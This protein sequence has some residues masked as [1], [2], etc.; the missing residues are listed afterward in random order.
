[1]KHIFSFFLVFLFSQ[2][3]LAQSGADIT[4]EA[5]SNNR[6]EYLTAGKPGTIYV[7]KRVN[8]AISYLLEYNGSKWNNISPVTEGFDGFYSMSH[9]GKETLYCYASTKTDGTHLYR[10][11]GT[12]WDTLPL[13]SL[14]GR[15]RSVWVSPNGQLF[16]RGKFKNENGSYFIATWKNEQWQ[17]VGQPVDHRFLNNAFEQYAGNNFGMDGAGTLFVEIFRYEKGN[18][19]SYIAKWDGKKWGLLDTSKY[20][21]EGSISNMAVSKN[22]NIYLAGYFKDANGKYCVP[23]WDGKKWN[24]YTT[25]SNIYDVAVDASDKLY[26]AGWVMSKSNYVVQTWE[27]DSWTDYASSDGFFQNIVFGNNSLYAVVNSGNANVYQLV[28]GGLTTKS[29][30][31]E[32]N[33]TSSTVSNSS[34]AVTNSST[35]ATQPAA[36]PHTDKKAKEMWSVYEDFKTAFLPKFKEIDQLLRSMLE[37]GD[38][39]KF[40]NQV[41]WKSSAYRMKQLIPPAYQTIQSIRGKISALSLQKG[42]NYLAD[43]LQEALNAYNRF[44][45]QTESLME[46][47]Q[48]GLIT[49]EMKDELDEMGKAGSNLNTKL[50]QLNKTKDSYQKRMAAA[51]SSQPTNELLS[52]G[53]DKPGNTT[54]TK[55]EPAVEIKTKTYTLNVYSGWADIFKNP[56]NATT[57]LRSSFGNKKPADVFKEAP[58]GWIKNESYVNSLQMR[59]SE[60]PAYTLEKEKE[61]FIS[62]AM[63]R[64]GWTKD[65]IKILT[66]PVTL[67]DGR[68]GLI[69]F[70]VCPD[71]KGMVGGYY[72]DCELA[73][74]SA[75]N[76][77]NL[78]TYTIFFDGGCP[79]LEPKDF[80]VWKD[81][82]KKVLLSVRGN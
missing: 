15:L 53:S 7:A 47:M 2:T 12:S 75:S 3:I 59:F 61:D 24:T 9:D 31:T 42:D 81:Y 74:P 51:A 62:L 45:V 57:Y 21:L 67:P 6:Y 4:P 20:P 54:T 41:V 64:T 72:M 28:P 8:Y 13:G 56:G 79:K 46:Q 11:K 16:I 50:L 29:K 18:S 70:Y 73:V 63:N 55:Q 52:T 69:L 48:Y 40:T 60:T 30:Q 32:S 36:P 26:A 33:T 19:R 14:N 49:D 35:T 43:D 39:G 38:N 17:P 10:R 44:L 27:N 82:F 78:I 25:S 77:N 5:N 71:T 58:N 68:K 80:G 1:M 34:S 66:E 37:V 76:K 22:G 65:K 23:A